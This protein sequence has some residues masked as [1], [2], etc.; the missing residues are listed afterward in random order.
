M[1]NESID[2]RLIRV[3][4]KLHNRLNNS[5]NMW[6]ITGSLNHALH[7][8]SLRPRDI[9]LINNKQGSYAIE[10][11]FKE[12]ISKN[13]QF[14]ET[15]NIRSYFG[16]LTIDGIAVDII[17]DI[18]IR[19]VNGIWEPQFENIYE[20]ETMKVNDISVP[21][22]SLKDEYAFYTK[23]GRKDRAKLIKRAHT[24]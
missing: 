3:L 21:V 1:S 5:E 7:G 24:L 22:F 11:L 15:N 12:N 16:V 8:I 18:E 23:L 10:Q 14:R 9:D 19:N 17:G 13:V 6:V 2:P 20:I 4:E